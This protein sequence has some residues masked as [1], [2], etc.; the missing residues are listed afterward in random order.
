MHMLKHTLYFII[1]CT[2]YCYYCYPIY[3]IHKCTFKSIKT[4]ISYSLWYFVDRNKATKKSISYIFSIIFSCTPMQVISAV[5]LRLIARFCNL[6]TSSNNEHHLLKSL[7]GSL[8]VD[9]TGIRYQQKFSNIK[10]HEESI[11]H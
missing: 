9:C 8:A 1:K 6:T 3:P 2:L 11:Y 5:C 4:F 7:F 10:N